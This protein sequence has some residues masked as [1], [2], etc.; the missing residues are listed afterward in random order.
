MDTRLIFRDRLYGLWS[1]GLL[2]VP[3]IIGF[4]SA[5]RGRALG[6]S[7]AHYSRALTQ[8]PSTEG[9]RVQSAVSR[10]SSVLN[11]T[12]DRTA[13][14]HRWSGRED[15]DERVRGPQGTRQ[16][17]GRKLAIRPSRPFF[18]KSGTQLKFFWQLF[19]K[20]TAPCKLVR[21]SIGGDT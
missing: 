18:G 10:K 4:G 5:L 3:P 9:E 12:G 7:G 11:H 21:G 6:K 14:R 19:T 15:Q 13:H 17:S 1:D 20:N 2:Y 16:K 8:F